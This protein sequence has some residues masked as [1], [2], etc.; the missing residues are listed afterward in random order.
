M[1]A[2][3]TPLGALVSYPV[4][5]A[6]GDA[7]LGAM[8]AGAGGILIY[9]VATHLRSEVEEERTD[10]TVLTLVTGVVVAFAI[11]WLEQE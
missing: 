3:S 1:A 11:R 8:L 5:H 9:V 6:I 7:T 2:L 4:V 10:Y